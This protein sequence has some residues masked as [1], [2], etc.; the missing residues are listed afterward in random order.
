MMPA[1]AKP[2][3]GDAV[4]LIKHALGLRTQGTKRHKTPILAYLYAEAKSWADGQP[5]PASDRDAHAEEVRMFVRL[6]AGAEVSFMHFTYS[7]VLGTFEASSV[8]AVCDHAIA[9]RKRFD[10]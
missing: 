2:P 1:S 9:V 5:L 7:D 8:K 10:C 3:F 4:Q 6:V